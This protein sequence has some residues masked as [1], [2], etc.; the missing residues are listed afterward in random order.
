[1]L[2]FWAQLAAEAGSWFPRFSYGIRCHY[3]TVQ[4]LTFVPQ[5]GLRWVDVDNNTINTWREIA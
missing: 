4:C 3:F 5:L 2:E 1:M